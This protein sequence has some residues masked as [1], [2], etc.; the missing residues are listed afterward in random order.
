MHGLRPRMPSHGLAR[1]PPV[2]QV[3]AEMSHGPPR[4]RDEFCIPGRGPSSESRPRPRPEGVA[5]KAIV[6]ERFGSP[7]VLQFVD[8]DQP[9]IGPADVLVRVHAAALNPYDW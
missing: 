1:R 7:D 3:P 6:Q 4:T 9:A 2:R 8:T 5:M